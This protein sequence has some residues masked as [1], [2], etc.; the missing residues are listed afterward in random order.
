MYVGDTAITHCGV[1]GFIHGHSVLLFCAYLQQFHNRFYSCALGEKQE[2]YIY[3]YMASG[4]MSHISTQRLCITSRIRACTTVSLKV[5][6]HI[7]SYHCS[8]CASLVCEQELKPPGNLSLYMCNSC[9]HVQVCLPAQT[10]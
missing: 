1:D 7:H 10:Q 2:Q 8:K 3:I 6:M 4:G 5:H 9:L